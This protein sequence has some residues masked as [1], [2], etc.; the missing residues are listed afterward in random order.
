M[1]VKELKV[2][3]VMK[4]FANF[5]ASEEEDISYVS[6]FVDFPDYKNIVK[7]HSSLCTA[8]TSE[9]TLAQ[10]FFYVILRSILRREKQEFCL[11]IASLIKG[12]APRRIFSKNKI[13]PIVAP[14]SAKKRDET[15][16]KI[17]QAL[18]MY[19]LAKPNVPVNLPQI[20]Y[21]D[22][23]NAGRQ[24]RVWSLW[25]VSNS[26]HLPSKNSLFEEFAKTLRECTTW[27]D[28]GFL[29]SLFVQSNLQNQIKKVMSELEAKH[30]K[31]AF[32]MFLVLKRQEIH[33]LS[34]HNLTR[35]YEDT[36]DIHDNGLDIDTI[37]P[38]GYKEIH[39]HTISDMNGN[40]QKRLT[41]LGLKG[42]KSYDKPAAVSRA[43]VDDVYEDRLNSY[44]SKHKLLS[45]PQKDIH[46][47]IFRK[48][49]A[50]HVNYDNFFNILL[51]K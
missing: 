27:T 41:K 40:L 51:E 3:C 5:M 28:S 23:Y 13:D 7:F 18:S 29:C 31:L 24:H 25:Y 20:N 16:L 35:F 4:A 15:D 46:N 11:N 30:E 42:S 49:A 10:Y 19:E 37:Q 38:Y 14:I 45:L 26:E 44:V 6:Y 34:L 9:R 12:N 21:N 32:C 39:A 1:A 33:D 36:F 50:E 8:E 43:K 17:I 48:A 47:S 2:G 22:I